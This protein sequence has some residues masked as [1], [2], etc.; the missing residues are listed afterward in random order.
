MK[1]W[2]TWAITNGVLIIGLAQITTGGASIGIE[3]IISFLFIFTAICNL[4][5]S[6]TPEVRDKL[7]AEGRVR[8]AALSNTISAAYICW[9]VY[10]GFWVTMVFVLLGWISIGVI[11]DG[12][13]EPDPT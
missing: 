9:L 12:K 13:S 1:R 5:G 8:P 10:L 11:Y 2:T 7:R 4:L 3:R 6:L